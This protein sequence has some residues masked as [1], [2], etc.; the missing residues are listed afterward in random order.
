MIQKLTSAAFSM[1]LAIQTSN[2]RADILVGEMSALSTELTR[3]DISPTE[4]SARPLS[5]GC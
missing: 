4:M 2:H 5:T 1:L 3:A